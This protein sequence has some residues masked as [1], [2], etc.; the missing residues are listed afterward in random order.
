MSAVEI[1]AN[2]PTLHSPLIR[3][4]QH[5]QKAAAMGIQIQPN[6]TWQ[7]ILS[8]HLLAQPTLGDYHAD[9]SCCLVQALKGSQINTTTQVYL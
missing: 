3:G 8:F 4:H 2:L 7:L 6:I 1:I 9:P 5:G